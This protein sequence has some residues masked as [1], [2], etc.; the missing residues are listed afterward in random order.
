MRIIK[1][2]KMDLPENWKCRNG[3][4]NNNIEVAGNSY[5]PLFLKIMAGRGMKSDGDIKNFLNPSP[6]LLH[7]PFLLKNLD[8]AVSVLKKVIEK[9]E[10]IIIFG[11][12][13]ADGIISSAII[14]NFLK[15]LGTGVDSYIPDRFEEG[16]DINIDFAREVIEKGRYG[17]IICVDCGTNSFGVRDFLKENP[18]SP[19]VI[20]C[21]HHNPSGKPEDYSGS[22][23]NYIIINPRL[24]GC[25]YPFKELSGAGVT[26]KFIVGTLRSLD[27]KYR[28][29]FKKNYL[30]SILDL[31]AVSTIA[32]VMPLTGENRVIVKKG[33]EILGH[34][35]NA[36]MKELVSASLKNRRNVNEY[37][38][39]YIIAPRLNAAGRIKNACDSFNLL[40]TDISDKMPLIG[41]LE[42]FNSQRQKIQKEI[43]DEINTAFDLDDIAR[44]Q[45]FFIAS[46][47]NWNEGVLGIVASEIVRNYNIPAILFSDKG[48]I[49]KGSGRSTEKFDLHYNIS[50]L[51]NLFISYG[52]HEKACGI[53]MEKGKYDE[54]CRRIK[55]I[56]MDK[57]PDSDLLQQHF[58]DVRAGFDEINYS[59]IREIEQMKPFGIGNPGPVVLSRNC[60]IE[61]MD[62]LKDGKY[63]RLQLKNSGITLDGIIFRVK[64]SQKEILFSKKSVDVIFS[65]EENCWRDLSSIQLK[66]LDIF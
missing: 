58:Y 64:K 16:Y 44:N 8:R 37:D 33:L 18:D 9:G 1:S 15:T 59:L 35:E 29:L 13:D 22:F 61:K 12:Y 4:I 36:G 11:D 5:S 60:F 32:D 20:V 34:T 41:R 6:G 53:K 49:L 26:F 3:G 2:E 46:S 55:D 39:G 19:P 50:C 7:D 48:K 65:P 66:I 24:P 56:A 42:N 62:F 51:K 27:D 21:D 25:P 52:G 23:D 63:V 10:N 47:G 45:K 28:K 57:I 14:Y 38:I 40:R 54:F 17:L 31:V 30:N 43:Y